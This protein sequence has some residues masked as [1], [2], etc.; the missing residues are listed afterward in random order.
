[1]KNIRLPV[2]INVDPCNQMGF[3]CAGRLIENFG[4][5]FLSP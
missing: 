4:L 1:M 3:G 2:T 5:R